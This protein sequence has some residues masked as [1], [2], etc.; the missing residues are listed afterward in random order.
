VPDVLVMP[1]ALRL[2]VVPI[3]KLFAPMART[4]PELALLKV[5][6]VIALSSVSV[7]DPEPES[8][9]MAEPVF[10]TQLQVGPPEELDQCA[11]LDQTPEPPNQ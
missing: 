5:A 10:G 4:M 3:V 11:V 6:T 1:P 9:R 8:M 2:H 7:P